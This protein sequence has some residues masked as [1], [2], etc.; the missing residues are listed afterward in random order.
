MLVQLV[1]RL[2]QGFQSNR[3]RRPPAFL[4]RGWGRP[5][6]LA[7]G[8]NGVL[9]HTADKKGSRSAMM[10]QA[11]KGHSADGVKSDNSAA[12]HA[13]SPQTDLMV[14][15]QLSV[16]IRGKRLNLFHSFRRFARWGQALG[17]PPGPV[18]NI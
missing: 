17:P 8:H 11:L 18:Q 6:S 13:I 14:E 7:E 4:A 1:N 10:D 12:L 2:G 9:R 16:H 15:Y 5:E 3:S